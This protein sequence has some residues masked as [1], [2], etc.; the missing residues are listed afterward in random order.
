MHRPI[1]FRALL[2]SSCATVECAQIPSNS[3][4]RHH[5]LGSVF[6]DKHVPVVR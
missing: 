3:W 2:K 1:D 6:W 5:D 4:C